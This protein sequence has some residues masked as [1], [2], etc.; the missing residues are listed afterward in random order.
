MTMFVIICEGIRE[1]GWSVL[2]KGFMQQDC[3]FIILVVYGRFYQNSAMNN[4]K[5]VKTKSWNF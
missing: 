4:S 3:L 1:D 2:N 5:F